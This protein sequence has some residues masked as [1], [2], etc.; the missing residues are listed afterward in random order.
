MGAI[1]APDGYGRNAPGWNDFSGSGVACVIRLPS[2]HPLL[3]HILSSIALQAL[4][5]DVAVQLRRDVD[6]PR[7]LAKSVTVE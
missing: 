6:R 7:N 3:D 2:Y 5:Y 4:A 1:S